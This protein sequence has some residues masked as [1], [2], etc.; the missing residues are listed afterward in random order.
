MIYQK[1]CISHEPGKTAARLLAEPG[2]TTHQI[3]SFIDHKTLSK[4]ERYMRAVEQKR[5]TQETM[6]KIS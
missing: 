6:I 1:V 4:D 2:R 3:V 5:L